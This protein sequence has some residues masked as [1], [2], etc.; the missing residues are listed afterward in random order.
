MQSSTFYPTKAVSGLFLL[1]LCVLNVLGAA[2]QNSSNITRPAADGCMPFNADGVSTVYT[3]TYTGG[4]ASPVWSTRGEIAIVGSNTG[5]SVNIRS[6]GF[7]KGRLYVTHSPGGICGPQRESVDV[8]KK[9]SK[10]N[11]PAE[12]NDVVGPACVRPGEIVTYSINSV[13]TGDPSEEIGI[14][15][16]HWILPAGWI[17]QYYSKDNSSITAKAPTSFTGPYTVKVYLGKCNTPQE[18]GGADDNGHMYFKQIFEKPAVPTLTSVP[19]CVP[20]VATSPFKQTIS[21]TIANY[22]ATLDYEWIVP[23][24]W[25]VLNSDNAVPTANIEIDNLTDDVRLLVSRKGAGCEKVEAEFKITRAVPVSSYIATVPTSDVTGGEACV[26]GSTATTYE[27]VG[28]PNSTVFNWT[29]TPNAGNMGGQINGATKGQMVS[30]TAGSNGGTLS[31]TSAECPGTPKTLKINVTPGQTGAITGLACLTPNTTGHVYQVAAVPGATGYDW[32]LS[33]GLSSTSVLRNGTNSI[34]VNI[35]ATGGTVSVKALN[36]TCASAAATRSV[37]LAPVAATSIIMSKTCINRAYAGAVMPDE[38]TFRV[39]N[40]VAG[41]TYNWSVVYPTVTG[42]PAPNWTIAPNTPTNGSAITYVTNGAGGGYTNNFQ[43]N[44]TASN[45]CGTSAPTSLD[46]I[47]L[48]GAGNATLTRSD[49]NKTELVIDENGEEQ[50]VLVK[51]GE[52]FKAELKDAANQPLSGGTYEWFINGTRVTTTSF[53]KADITGDGAT[54]NVY[55]TTATSSTRI[56]VVITRNS[57]RTA[58][59]TTSTYT[60]TTSTAR[61]G[62]PENL[63]FSSLATVYPNPSSGEFTLALKTDQEATVVLRNVQGKAVYKTKQREKKAKVNVGTLPNGMYF[64]HVTAGGRTVVK[65]I[66]IQK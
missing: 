15:K 65:K 13:L 17:L 3:Y 50:E 41:Q 55:G 59:E 20:T 63:A 9:F 6:T 57:C 28:A 40:P 54:L 4:G 48:E 8:Y 42:T 24:N 47:K 2:A 1:L 21:L 14:D 16:Y 36:G 33:G 10:I 25:T 56:R 66:Q 60:G 34:T 39:A 29:F 30:V 49:L 37:A 46:N 12:N 38:V 32:A 62:S 26:N 58:R 35:G 18:Y 31:V 23:S 64:L 11:L 22:D 52:S 61:Q 53:P 5:P 44:V 51:Y 19:S 45:A 27:L 7:A 43:V